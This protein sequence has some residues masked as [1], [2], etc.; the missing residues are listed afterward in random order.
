MHFNDFARSEAGRFA[1]FF[2]YFIPHLVDRVAA[3]E[4]LREQLPIHIVNISP[5][6]AIISFRNWRRLTKNLFKIK[7]ILNRN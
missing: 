6:A 4:Y 2:D 7:M 3:G 5:W 1:V